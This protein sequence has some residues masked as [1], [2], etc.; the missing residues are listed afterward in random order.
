MVDTQVVDKLVDASVAID[1][2]LEKILQ[3]R[4][5]MNKVVAVVVV[6]R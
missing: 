5:T 1:V 3:G 6:D 4:V 2:F